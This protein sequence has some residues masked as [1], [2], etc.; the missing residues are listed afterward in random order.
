MTVQVKDN[1]INLVIEQGK[2]D[3]G[4]INAVAQIITEDSTLNGGLGFVDLADTPKTYSGHAGQTLVVDKNAT[5]LEFAELRPQHFT[6][7]TDTF[8]SYQGKAGKVLAVNQ[9]ESGITVANIAEGELKYFWQLG[10]VGSPSMNA[11]MLL[12]VSSDGESITYVNGSNMLE[13]IPG[14]IT[15]GDGQQS[16]SNPTI[17]VDSKGRI[18]AATSG[19]SANTNNCKAN[20][21]VYA[22][23]NPAGQGL[24]LSSTDAFADDDILMKPAGFTYPMNDKLTFLYS[25]S[26]IKRAITVTDDLGQVAIDPLTTLEIKRTVNTIV[27][28][29]RLANDAPAVIEVPATLSANVLDTPAVS[30]TEN[31]LTLKSALD[32]RIDPSDMPNGEYVPQSDYSLVTVKDSV[33]ILRQKLGGL[34]VGATE[35]TAVD[36]ATQ[37]FNVQ[38]AIGATQFTEC[39]ILAANKHLLNCSYRVNTAFDS[40]L[41]FWLGIK[42]ANPV[43]HPASSS[44]FGQFNLPTTTGT[45]RQEILLSRS[46]DSYIYGMIYNPNVP[47][48]SGIYLGDYSTLA[49]LQ[50]AYPTTNEGNYAVA[51][52]SA[53]TYVYSATNGWLKNTGTGAFNIF[54]QYEF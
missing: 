27:L 49:E 40:G 9:T 39:L 20:G 35:Y 11:G 52:V 47:V 19:S 7:L 36:L 21:V 17:T 8:S 28:N 50:A 14:L 15:T 48:K 33:D 51:G 37:E 54:A 30:T 38:F 23:N 10:D 2:S 29:A 3:D 24:T 53:T 42:D 26:K 44:Y 43:S 16:F 6:S 34:M 5:K 25:T 13:D 4:S 22:V 32:I 31:V 46:A 45:F 41:Q 12:Q 18:I 1:Q